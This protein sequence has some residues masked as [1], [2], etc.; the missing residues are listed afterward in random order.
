MSALVAGLPA[1]LLFMNM[2]LVLRIVRLDEPSC[3]LPGLLPLFCCSGPHAEGFVKDT[4][5]PDSP[6]TWLSARSVGFIVHPASGGRRGDKHL[7]MSGPSVCVYEFS[8][9][10]CLRL[11]AKSWISPHTRSNC[12][13][14]IPGRKTPHPGPRGM[15]TFWETICVCV[16]LRNRFR[17]KHITQKT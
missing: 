3:G 1:T 8:G 2:S 4:E 15:C 7:H 17:G 10:L 13:P 12:W 11:L 5:G 6:K 9:M 14:P 16:F